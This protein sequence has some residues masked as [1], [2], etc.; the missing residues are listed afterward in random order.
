M[1]AAATC[2]GGMGCAAGMPPTD[3]DVNDDSAILLRACNSRACLHTPR[4]FKFSHAEAALFLRSYA[5]LMLTLGNFVTLRTLQY[6]NINRRPGGT[7]DIIRYVKRTS[8][9]WATLAG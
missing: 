1:C 6:S 8:G 7:E 9:L 3:E 4:G 5:P 2:R